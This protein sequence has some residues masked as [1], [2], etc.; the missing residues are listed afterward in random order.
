VLRETFARL[1]YRP[2]IT[3]TAIQKLMDDCHAALAYVR[4]GRRALRKLFAFA[5]S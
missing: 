2:R 1:G 4:P 3:S 5:D